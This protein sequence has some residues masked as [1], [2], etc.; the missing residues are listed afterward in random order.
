MSSTSSPASFADTLAIV[1]SSSSTGRL[2][3]DRV[4]PVF[5]AIRAHLSPDRIALFTVHDGVA[6]P[7]WVDDAEGHA[8][9][10][11][12]W[13]ELSRTVVRSAVESGERRTADAFDGSASGSAADLGIVAA[14]AVPHGHPPEVVL[15]VDFRDPSRLS[16]LARLDALES[17]A[18]LLAPMRTALVATSNEPAVTREFAPTLES[19][20]APPGMRRV[21]DEVRRALD[22]D[23]HVL[24]L[25]E[26]GT[27]KTLLATAL[28]EHGR[29]RPIVRTMLGASD[30]LNTIASELFGHERGAFSGATARR[31]GT[32]EY[33]DGGVLVLDEILN[34]PRD[35]QHLLLDLAQ[36]G[37]YR[38]LGHDA[39]EPR[40]A[41][42]RILA[43][44]NGDLARAV[45]EGR[46][47]EDLYYRL[48]THVI[49]LPPL[50]E[51]RVDIPALA[52][53]LL[54]RRGWRARVSLGLDAR[55][56]LVAPGYDWPGNL[57]ELE[58]EV[59]R[60]AG[61]AAARSGPVAGVITADDFDVFRRPRERGPVSAQSGDVE[62]AERSLLERWRELQ[63]R[64]EE[65]ER[66][67]QSLIAEALARHEGVVAHAARELG[68]ART[69]LASRLGKGGGSA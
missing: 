2:V 49:V 1:A 62:L 68:V 54:D 30:D 13:E 26:T 34:L 52:E 36:F 66:L 20:L 37:T 51:R 31:R 10:D 18:A 8:P 43:V 59:L 45:R 38:P 4:K 24:V 5:A 19:L 53:S 6:S 46:F 32:V 25:G 47:R 23:G 60:A 57:R 33:A 35:A 50:R 64:R 28:A 27:G 44:T 39:R 56:A 69:T 55:R 3:D 61:R 48:A 40:K 9:P 42:V 16:G 63:L 15:Y 7:V 67:E 14:V 65:L 22:T 17:A 29:A 12:T 11:G 21:A 41:K 58:A